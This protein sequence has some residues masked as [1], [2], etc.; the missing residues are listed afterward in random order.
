MKS[1]VTVDQMLAIDQQTMRQKQLSGLQLM[2]T[3]AKEM[4]RELALRFPTHEFLFLCGPGNNGG[5]G[6][7]TAY[8]LASQGHQTAWVSWGKA[9]KFKPP[10]QLSREWTWEKVFKRV[11][12]GNLE[13]PLVVVDAL[14]GLQGKAHLES[15]LAKILA[16][17]N[18]SKKIRR[19]SLDVPTGVSCRE[20]RAH[21]HTFKA[22]LTLCVGF[23]KLAFLE[24]GLSEY[25][26]DLVMIDPG[27]VSV[28]RRGRIQLI[29][30]QDATL[31]RPSPVA[32][33]KGR[34]AII[35]GSPTMPGAGIIAATAAMRMGAGYAA[36]YWAQRSPL[37][38]L[39]IE[40]AGFLFHPRWR[41]QDLLSSEVWVVGP[42]GKPA[43]KLPWASWSGRAVID[44]SALSKAT[45]QEIQ[46]WRRTSALCVLTPHEGEARALLKEKN[47]PRSLNEKL[48]WIDRL[49]DL[50]GQSVY[51]KGAPGICGFQASAYDHQRSSALQ[52]SVSKHLD[53]VNSYEVVWS[54]SPA[55]ATAGSGDCLAGMMAGAFTRASSV[56]EAARAALMMQR[57]FVTRAGLSAGSLVNDQLKAIAPL[58]VGEEGW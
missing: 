38:K 12:S 13:K 8:E 6:L 10:P 19:V 37:W 46:S 24:K 32:Y 23:P 47:F 4:A 36:L 51:L 7:W 35:G 48:E 22:H 17:V 44:A 58:R 26:G 21:S 28:P 11:Q 29:E 5:D 50:T 34:V 20:G 3:V 2:R 16:E 42:G 54:Q 31:P 14:F 56:V 25:V 15:R 30:E 1:F 49:R 27:F 57:F 53:Y 52:R 41:P 43:Q 33:K 18:Q 40:D 45:A 55:L 9:Q 39:K